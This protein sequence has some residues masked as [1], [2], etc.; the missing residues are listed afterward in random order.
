MYYN[1]RGY[2]YKVTRRKDGSL[3]YM[4][5]GRRAT[6]S[7]P[8]DQRLSATAVRCS[9]SKKRTSCANRAACHW[10][11]R[12]CKQKKSRSQSRGR[13]SK[14][15]RR[16]KPRRKSKPR[17]RSKPRRK[18]KPKSRGQTSFDRRL[19]EMQRMDREKTDIAGVDF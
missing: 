17:R 5:D 10:D 9:K 15:R 16:S 13:K 6:V 18:S 2:S 8:E 14:P 1:I 3:F 11:K 4:R 7:D 19:A 12:S